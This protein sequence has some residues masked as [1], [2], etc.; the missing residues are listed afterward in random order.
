MSQTG[1][2][3]LISH[4]VLT[5]CLPYDDPDAALRWLERAFGLVHAGPTLVTAGGIRVAVEARRPGTPHVAVRLLVTTDD[6]DEPHRRA[7][8]AGAPVVDGPDDAGTFTVA[9]PGGH[10]W[11]FTRPAGPPAPDDA[12]PAD[13]T[14]PAPAGAL[15]AVL[16]G[17][18]SPQE[19]LGRLTDLAAPFAVRVAATL[20]LADLIE[21]GVRGLDA[22]AGQAGADPDALGRLLRYLA[23][24][25]LFTEPAPDEFALT[26]TGRL[27]RES[28]PAGQRS[29]LDL[30]ELGARMD[31]AYIGLLHAVRTGEP[32]YAAVH[33]RSLWADLDA[34][35]HYR[36]FFDNLMMSQ[37]HLTAPQVAALYDWSGVGR[38]VDVGG[39]SGALLAELLRTHG[40]LR[41]TLVDRPDPAG[42]TARR[43]AD[44][45][46]ADRAEVVPGD[47]F[48]P[49]PTGGDV[50]VVARAITD[51]NDRD[52]TAILRRCAEATGDGGRV[53]IVE[54][55]PT[56]PHVPHLSPFDLQML[57][58]VGGRE[59]TLA[60][61]EALV[62]AAGLAVTR[63]LHGRGGLAL[64]ECAAVAGPAADPVTDAGSAAADGK[65]AAP[66]LTPAG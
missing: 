33:G 53:L 20:R 8:A 62:A 16:D 37:N 6:V 65:G 41:G 28:G 50:Y 61:F 17:D 42:T 18:A 19:R 51:W 31:L 13:G 44:Q 66:T 1:E 5:P 47:F 27:L 43:L 12:P 32:G 63:V 40:H 11:T 14:P 24:R 26:E 30:E 9:D 21:S 29:F 58:V 64:I 4:A 56:E 36:R 25:G 39:G 22:L 45:G 60:D 2:P 59:R 52:A 35:P 15:P 23:H 49:L 7:V 34:V 10:L 3:A 57:A 54:V 55:L 38:V 48:A 46:L